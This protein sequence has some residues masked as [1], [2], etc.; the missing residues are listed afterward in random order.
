MYCLDAT[1]DPNNGILV[2]G[3][4]DSVL[5]IWHLGNGQALQTIEPPK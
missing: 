2:A 5:R 4:H 3:G 1:A